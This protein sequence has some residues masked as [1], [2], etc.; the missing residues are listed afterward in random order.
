MPM[1]SSTANNIELIFGNKQKRY[2][3]LIDN[4][5][6]I[7][8]HVDNEGKII[9]INKAWERILGYSLE[10]SL[11]RHFDS[12]IYTEDSLIA[13]KIFENLL[14]HEGEYIPHQFRA[15]T[16][17]GAIKWV[18]VFAWIS[19]DSKNKRIGIFG[20]VTDITEQKHIKELEDELLQVSIK[21]TGTPISAIPAAYNFALSRIGKFFD[22]DRAYIFEFSDDGA[23]MSNTHEWCRDGVDP[24]IHILQNMSCDS[25]PMWINTLKQ[26]KEIVIPVVA[27]LDDRWRVERLTMTGLGIR[28]VL[29]IPIYVDNTLVG[30]LGL[31]YTRNTKQFA[32]SEVNILK[33]WGNMFAGIMMN[34]R[35]D[36]LLSQAQRNFENFF[37]ANN[38]FLFVFDAEGKIVEINDAV[39]NRLKYN[40]ED[41]L[42]KPVEIIHPA[43]RQLEA[44][45]IVYK[46]YA[47][48]AD[49]CT[50]PLIS[51]SGE[52]IPVETIVKNGYWNDKPVYFAFCRDVSE[53]L[54][55]EEKFSRAFQ[56]N[57][58]LM[59]IINM[60][61][62]R[63]IDVNDTMVKHTGY[64]R[65]EVIG[66]TVPELKLFRNLQKFDVDFDFIKNNLPFQ[67]IEADLIKKDGSI[68]VG[69]FSADSI[70]VG[71]D[72]CLLITMIDITKR[73]EAEN[74]LVR[75]TKEAEE[76]NR[77]K[78]E[79]LSRMSH[80]LRTPMNSIL[81][82]AQLLEMN[83]DLPDSQ[84]KGVKHIM[85]NGRHLLKLINEV[86][87]MARIES[88]K[89][90]ISIENI[91]IQET[92]KEA[93]DI[94]KPLM[95]ERN[96]SLKLLEN[97]SETIFVSADKQRLIQ[98]LVNLLSNAVKY[99]KPNGSIILNFFV[100]PVDK[101]FIR[102]TIKDTGIG[103][104]DVNIPRLFI[105]FE[106]IITD[107]SSAEGT[108]L[109][110]PI[111]LELMHIMGGNIGVKSQYG[112]GSTFWIDVPLAEHQNQDMVNQDIAPVIS[113]PVERVTTILYIEDNLSNTDLI[114]QVMSNLRPNIKLI[115]DTHGKKTMSLAKKHQPDLILL[116][117]NLPDIH[118]GEVLTALKG[119][120]E[121]NSIPVVVLTAD[122]TQSQMK[123]LML[124]GAR[125]YL[126]K[127][128][129]LV[130]LLI[131]IDKF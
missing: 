110:L 7:I 65:D 55:S 83:T 130:S 90:S 45:K 75:A 58:V 121:T 46:M 112:V 20:S 30:F 116:D 103:I 44:K 5:K 89:I 50:V 87:D 92:I 85:N 48:I 4:L 79:F 23:H 22:A 32:D 2:K 19:Q 49:K 12:F 72:Q 62:D 3:S 100:N 18:E 24:Q 73:K 101:N 1:D 61:T 47:G 17:T 91:K 131:E 98:V 39:K 8:F 74:E 26:N 88:G 16:K 120:A 28:S 37:R 38:D 36:V 78:S 94:V 119:D 76:A 107:E 97:L 29:I 122:A 56:S 31:D 13:Q 10:E 53:I 11:G 70:Y 41:L 81:G 115:C 59:G 99:N 127:P 96:I 52:V 60:E 68:M 129:D 43:E 105:P 114:K 86:L 118:G 126:T 95:K 128:V 82:F 14:K 109:G 102:I 117:L 6:D 106:R 21:L 27:E 40:P 108:G 125:A 34:Q 51:K 93:V 124:A 33:V 25:I 35:K 123:K 113:N 77:S 64:E 9:F 63:F 80:E 15:I 69:L 57:T 54:L 66:K 42:G 67:E 71:K 104:E 111:A 84:R